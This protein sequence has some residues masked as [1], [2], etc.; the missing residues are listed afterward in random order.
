MMKNVL[1]TDAQLEAYRQHLIADYKEYCGAYKRYSGETS[2]VDYDID[3]EPGTKYTRVVHLSGWGGSRSAHSFIDAQ[4]N[5]WKAASRK[6]PAKNFI[7]GNILNENFARCSW[8]G[9]W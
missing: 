6:A 3:F 4:G 9:C 5:I 1:Y 7:R 8:T 2:S